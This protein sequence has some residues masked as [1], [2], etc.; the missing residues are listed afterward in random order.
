MKR[1]LE[2]CRKYGP[3]GLSCGFE[4]APGVTTDETVKLLSALEEPWYSTSVHFRADRPDSVAS[5]EETGRNSAQKRLWYADV[6]YWKLQ[7]S[8]LYAKGAGVYRGSQKR[9]GRHYLRL[10]SLHGVLHRHRYRGN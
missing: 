6:P 3:V 8:R 2:A 5:I 4:Y 10:L 1:E 9:W 7:C